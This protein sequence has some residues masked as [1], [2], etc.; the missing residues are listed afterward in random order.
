M[1]KSKNP[2][3]TLFEPIEPRKHSPFFKLVAL[4]ATIALILLSIRG[5]FLLIHP[6]PKMDIG[7]EDIQSF[8]PT[9]LAEPFTS[10]RPEEVGQVINGVRG[11]IKQVANRIASSSC[12]NGDRVCQTKAIFYFVRDE[13]TYVP[14]DKFHD[15][16]ENPLSVL[17]TGGSDCED[18]SVLLI[19]MQK[20][21]GNQ[22]RLVF[23][24]GH[25]YAQVKI[26]NYKNR[27]LNME[28]TCKT[29][30]FNEVPTDTLIKPKEY[31]EL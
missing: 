8:L 31:Y 23:V 6:E 3:E 13:I 11:T 19:A 7:L 28:A 20:A 25:A 17:K 18:M 29:C 21:I 26:P 24:P 30:S 16:L 12:K 1:N 22:A 15:E 9:D 14:D 2:L 10:H 4:L 5:I 27:W